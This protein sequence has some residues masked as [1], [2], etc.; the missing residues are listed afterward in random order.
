MSTR[1]NLKWFSVGNECVGANPPITHYRCK[2]GKDDNNILWLCEC[3]YRYAENKY[4]IRFDYRTDE[5]WEFLKDEVIEAEDYWL[6][7]KKVYH[8]K[9]VK[10]T[11]IQ[12]EIRKFIIDHNIHHLDVS[13]KLVK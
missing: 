2:L 8:A 11:D 1:L 5:Q 9:F 13:G 12:N 10:Y 3:K 7:S 6:A 4:L